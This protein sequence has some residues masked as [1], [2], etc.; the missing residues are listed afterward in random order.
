MA[1]HTPIFWQVPTKERGMYVQD[2]FNE[3][4]YMDVKLCYEDINKL[5]W[6][7]DDIK[8]KVCHLVTHYILH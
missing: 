8:K 6:T 1:Y 2:V 7:M 4:C 5:G 3:N